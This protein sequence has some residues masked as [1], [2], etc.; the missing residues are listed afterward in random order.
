[1]KSSMSKAHQM[2]GFFDQKREK[3]VSFN[4]IRQSDAKNVVAAFQYLQDS[5]NGTDDD[6]F[7]NQR[8]PR[9]FTDHITHHNTFTNKR[10]P[11]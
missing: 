11:T 3:S 5:E 7:F 4:E 9:A 8:R 6:A 10:P 1:M 2:K